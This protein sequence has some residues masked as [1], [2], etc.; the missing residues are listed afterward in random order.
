M[1]KLFATFKL[2]CN[3]TMFSKVYLFPF[4]PN[5]N[6]QGI[7]EGSAGKILATMLLHLVIPF[8]IMLLHS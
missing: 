8:A 5:S 2:I 1:G 3:M 7:G 6:N 4:D